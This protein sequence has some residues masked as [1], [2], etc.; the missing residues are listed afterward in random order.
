MKKVII[1]QGNENTGKTATLKIVIKMLLKN[2]AKLLVFSKNFGLWLHDYP[3][4]GDI[5]AIIEYNGEFIFITTRGDYPKC[6]QADFDSA[7]QIT[8][9]SLRDIDVFICAA[10]TDKQVEKVFNRKGLSMP[11][12]IIINKNPSPTKANDTTDANEVFIHI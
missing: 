7:L 5:W 12:S 8:N 9:L 1:L 4:V 10:H 6:I 3:R 2:N 11:N